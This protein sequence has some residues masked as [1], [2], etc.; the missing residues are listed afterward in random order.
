[1]SRC[2]PFLFLSAY[3][4]LPDCNMDD[5]LAVKRF[6]DFAQHR[7]HPLVFSRKD[8]I[9]GK[10]EKYLT[11]QFPQV[12]KIIFSCGLSSAD[13]DSLLPFLGGCSALQSLTL[14]NNNLSIR[15]HWV[16]E[17][18]RLVRVP[19]KTDGV[20][21]SHFFS[22]L[23]GL[24]PHLRELHLP[25][26]QLNLKELG[27]LAKTP[28]FQKGSRLTRIDLS[29]NVAVISKTVGQ[30]QPTKPKWICKTLGWCI[31]SRLQRAEAVKKG[32]DAGKEG[33]DFF[34]TALCRGGL[35]GKANDPLRSRFYRESA[36]RKFW[37]SFKNLSHLQEL[38]VEG[39]GLDAC[40][41]TFLAAALRDRTLT[42]LNVSHNAWAGQRIRAIFP[43]VCKETLQSFSCENNN[44]SHEVM[45]ALFM[46]LGKNYHITYLSIGGNYVQ[47]STLW[48]FL[49]GPG[50][51]LQTLHA[52]NIQISDSDI[53]SVTHL[54]VRRFHPLVTLS[55]EGDAL[56][57]A[58]LAKNLQFFPKLQS[59][60]LTKVSLIGDTASLADH[61]AKLRLRDLRLQF[62][63]FPP[64]FP[65]KTK[66]NTTLE[67]KKLDSLKKVM[68]A[69]GQ[70]HDLT[71]LYFDS[72]SV[73]CLP[74]LLH[75]LAG[76]P[77]LRCLVMQ[78]NSLPEDQI[79]KMIQALEKNPTFR[80]LTLIEKG[81]VMMYK[82]NSSSK[83]N[84]QDGDP[85]KIRRNL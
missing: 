57:S 37:M 35:A 25:R 80:K 84:N 36:L 1:M 74:M 29:H 82:R 28:W 3:S 38:S 8:W 2:F 41:F 45:N 22:V 18:G 34:T 70:C 75:N 78:K 12:R 5:C 85:K 40:S 54:P 61:L 19:S 48:R 79:E 23:H 32:V 46:A 52:G 49:M 20:V 73:S 33:V 77:R 27:L 14:E 17:G 69:L 67:K 42:H 71:A 59:L 81:S 9:Q 47:G 31:E 16:R 30:Y 7:T 63:D 50:M 51:H 6:Q 60:H 44:L 21:F 64:L 53:E 58:T 62:L 66:E 15:R 72:L 24:C 76:W 56:D 26:N 13:L 43:V 10:I 4:A 55:L 83:R 11:M 68:K 39:M 65:C